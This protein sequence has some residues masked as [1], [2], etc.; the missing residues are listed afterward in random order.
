[1]LNHGEVEAAES[2][3]DFIHKLKVCLKELKESRRNLLVIEGV[4]LAGDLTEVCA[5]NDETGQLIRIFSA[6]I[7][8]SQARLASGG[9]TSRV[10]EDS[11][12][13]ENPADSALIPPGVPYWISEIFRAAIDEVEG[14]LS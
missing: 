10:R 12:S 7:R 13:G 5:L 9:D 3:R 4:P 6:S 1:M 2:L 11:V 14:P 8:T